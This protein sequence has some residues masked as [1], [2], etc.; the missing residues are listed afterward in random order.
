MQQA[1]AADGLRPL[2]IAL[3]SYRSKPHCGGQGV[4]VRA[5]SRELV[6][7]GHTVEVLSGPPYPELDRVGGAGPDLTEV[8]SLDLYREPDPF[9]I[10]HVREFRS[11]IDVLEFLLMCTAAFPEP[12]TFSLRAARVLRPRVRDFDLVHDNQTLGYGLLALR[13]SGVPV[14][15]T[16]HHPIT[17]DREHDLEAASGLRKRLSTRRWY[18]FLRMQARVVRRLPA[19][20]TVSES[21]R[22]DIVRD[23]GVPHERL[24]VVPV[25]VEVD[26]FRP[27]TR[28]RVPGRIVAT[29]SA[30]VPV[31]GLVP[32]L[33]AVAKLR[34]ERDV[35]LVVVGRPKPGGVA[36]ATIERLGIA[37]AVRFVSGVSEPDLVELFGSAQ[38]AVVPSLY[39]GFSLPAIETL[40]CAT[41]LVATTAGALP[42]VVGPDGISALHVPPGDPEALAAAIGRVLDDPELAARLGAAGR[43]RVV[44]LYTWRAV[45]ERTVEW[46]R[47]VLEE[48]PC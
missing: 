29:A 43:A 22:A 45:A 2:R 4:Y 44:E 16:V 21:S 31:K 40:A 26:V 34:T 27:P 18:S 11:P 32:L 6:A 8:P 23:F 35:E 15:A 10:P 12:L 9:R 5:L 13:R 3:L 39:E 24:T 20:L 47:S 14:V 25:G 48:H 30:D 41:P 36:A 1:P 37:D 33:E 38:V 17:V 28:P 7:L 19:V 46:Y 42:E